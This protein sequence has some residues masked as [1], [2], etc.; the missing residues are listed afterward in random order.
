M[1]LVGIQ[2]FYSSFNRIIEG[3]NVAP[4]KLLG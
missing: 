3:E 4:E 2:V 1:L